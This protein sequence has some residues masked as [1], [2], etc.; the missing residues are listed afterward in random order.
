[1]QK[2]NDLIRARIETFSYLPLPPTANEENIVLLFV[3]AFLHFTAGK[4]KS[5]TFLFT[6]KVQSCN[7]LLL[8]KLKQIVK[9]LFLCLYFVCGLLR[10]AK[11]RPTSH[12]QLWQ[13]EGNIQRNGAQL[14]L[15]SH[16]ESAK[17][18]GSHFEGTD[19]TEEIQELYPK[20][21]LWATTHSVLSPPF[22]KSA[23]KEQKLAPV[24][25][26]QHKC[27]VS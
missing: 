1:M 5:C 22:A 20:S 7:T 8:R 21:T 11:Q 26:K 6:S 27:F 2:T 10:K 17:R 19:A 3:H 25:R 9:T 13:G 18:S 4:K 12:S 15:S 14:L 16:L 23:G 24:L